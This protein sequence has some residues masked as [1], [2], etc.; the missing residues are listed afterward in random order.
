MKM[1]NENIS[2]KSKYRIYSISI[3][4]LLNKEKTEMNIS[5]YTDIVNKRKQA[6]VN[7]QTH[8]RT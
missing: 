4:S 5:S 2:M 3:N 6:Y 7:T 1:R 8:Q